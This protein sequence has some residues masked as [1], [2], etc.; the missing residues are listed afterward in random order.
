MSVIP[1]IP[2]LCSSFF[3]SHILPRIFRTATEGQ[4]PAFGHLQSRAGAPRGESHVGTGTRS[5][6]QASWEG[7]GSFRGDGICVGFPRKGGTS[8]AGAGRAHAVMEES[9]HGE[10]GSLGSGRW[11]GHPCV[12]ELD[13]EGDRKCKLGPSQ[14]HLLSQF[15][16]AYLRALLGVR[17]K[18]EQPF[19]FACRL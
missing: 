13:E 5:M 1:S 11:A 16:L 17:R 14:D 18:L 19:L 6:E 9:E 8:R 15:L 10:F 12:G 2:F 3:F 4:V 7:S